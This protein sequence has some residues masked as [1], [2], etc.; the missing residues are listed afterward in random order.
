[1]SKEKIPS[2]SERAFRFTTAIWAGFAEGK[3]TVDVPP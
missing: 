1:M 3:T 2:A